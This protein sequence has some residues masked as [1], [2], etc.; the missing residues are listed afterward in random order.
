MNLVLA[1]RVVNINSAMAKLLSPDKYIDICVSVGIVPNDLGELLIAKRPAHWMG[2]G[3]WEFPGGKIEPNEDAE[4]ALKRELLEEVGIV[5][6][7]CEPL[8]KLT[9]V[10]P[11][12]K[13]TLNAW[14]V[15]SYSGQAQG[16]EGQEI[17]WRN[18]SVLKDI[19]MLPANRA[20][21]TATQLPDTYLITPD[22]H[23]ELSFLHDLNVLLAQS[24]RRIIQLR[25]KNLSRSEYTSLARKVS[26]ICQQHQ[27]SLML[28]NDDIAIL[29]DVDN[30]GLHLHS[31]Q[32]FSLKERPL[33]TGHW[34][35]A[36]CHNEIEL[37][38]AEE[39]NVDFITISPIN[40]HNEAQTP[41]GWANFAKLVAMANIPVFASGGMTAKDIA[42]AKL[43]GAQGVAFIPQHPIPVHKG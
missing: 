18:P 3:F 22:C 41:L 11:E 27:A 39:L 38:R 4:A 15:T 19:N 21:V 25:S 20:I 10:Y 23:D 28:H 29:Q 40:V 12:R 9:Y 13:V 8:I 32:L 6:A 43:A 31:A 34:V 26:A 2:G 24:P 37:K 17:C 42:E 33:P 16:L 14:W 35:S 5:V 36:S 30:A 1:V 7:N